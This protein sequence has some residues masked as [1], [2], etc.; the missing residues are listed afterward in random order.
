MSAVFD[1]S[2]RLISS[3][4]TGEPARKGEANDM[5]QKA[6]QEAYEQATT[7]DK[8][9]GVWLTAYQNGVKATI[10]LTSAA[11]LPTGFKVA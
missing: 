3:R 10:F 1:A 9:K 7:F 11:S 6:T 2:N 4:S 5:N 8:N